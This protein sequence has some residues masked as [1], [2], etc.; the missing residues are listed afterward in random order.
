MRRLGLPNLDAELTI[1]NE[2][3][4][5]IEPNSDTL[6]YAVPDRRVG[7]DDRCRIQP[8]PPLFNPAECFVGHSNGLVQCRGDQA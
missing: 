7:C 3:L 8:C 5:T 4:A 2:E 6:S 1:L